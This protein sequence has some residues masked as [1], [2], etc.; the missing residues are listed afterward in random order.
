MAL[1][2]IQ[3]CKYIFKNSLCGEQTDVILTENLIYNC[4]VFKL[5]MWQVR[6][7]ILFAIF[8][9]KTIWLV[10]ENMQK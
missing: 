5:C 2:D 8:D 9:F 10:F 1:K 6:Q 7:P 3:F 4:L